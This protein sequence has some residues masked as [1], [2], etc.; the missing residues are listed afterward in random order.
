MASLRR[1]GAACAV[2]LGVSYVLVGITYFL[3]PVAQ[4]GGPSSDLATVL[5]SVAE[6]PTFFRL[7]NW[8]F[9]LGA[10]FAIGAVLAISEAVRPS[11]E[12]WARWTANLAVIGFAVTA[13]DSFRAVSVSE[14]IAA[15][16]VA[17]DAATKAAIAARPLSLD[18]QGWLGFGVVGVWVAVTSALALRGRA[19]PAP[20][21]YLGFAVAVLYWLVVAG[22]VLRAPELIAIAAGLGGV[23]AAPIF[24]IGI[25]LSLLRERAPAMAAA[26]RGAP[27]R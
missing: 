25:G 22:N 8:E 27:A 3:L 4:R 23:V 20:L 15:A 19:L 18:P 16:Y 21:G 14:R 9:A 17:G 13:I 7:L 12:G 6:N 11:G 2:A 1:I 24:F 10:L 26:A 5:P